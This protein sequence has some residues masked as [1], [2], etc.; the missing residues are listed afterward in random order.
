MLSPAGCI[1]REIRL[2]HPAEGV[3]WDHTFVDMFVAVSSYFILRIP[4]DLRVQ[5]L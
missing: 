4:Y 3:S 2:D 5:R 1:V